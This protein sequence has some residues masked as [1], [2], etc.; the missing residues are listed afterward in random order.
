VLRGYIV[1]LLVVLC[2]A[3]QLH[4]MAQR[5]WWLFYD[6]MRQAARYQGMQSRMFMYQRMQKE[7][8]KDNKY[9]WSDWFKPWVV[10]KPSMIQLNKII[11]H[12]EKL[13]GAKFE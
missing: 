3:L 5:A 1:G 12:R 4:G 6:T 2:M 11:L 9:S 7:Q 13:S 10:K 8:N